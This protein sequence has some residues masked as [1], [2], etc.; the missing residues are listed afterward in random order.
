MVDEKIKL[1]EINAADTYKNLEN[2]DPEKATKE[3]FLLY[4]ASVA[5]LN[6]MKCDSSD[7]KLP[8]SFANEELSYADKYLQIGEIEIACQELEHALY[9]INKAQENSQSM[10]DLDLLKNIKIKYNILKQSIQ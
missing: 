4:G 5:I 6:N 1:W 2:I 9:F 10:A 3:Q 8:I 7:N